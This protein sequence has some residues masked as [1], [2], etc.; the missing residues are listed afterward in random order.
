MIKVLIIAAAVAALFMMPYDDQVPE[1][2]ATPYERCIFV[3]NNAKQCEGYR[4]KEG[5]EQ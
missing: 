5:E 3:Y 4:P 2:Q 1:Q